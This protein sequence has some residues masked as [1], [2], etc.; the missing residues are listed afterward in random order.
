MTTLHVATQ[1]S[2]ETQ[3]ANARIAIDRAA[4][5]ARARHITT[6]PGQ[7][8]T[9]LSKAAEAVAY[10]AAGAPEDLT[11]W[12]WIQA[13]ASAFNLSGFEAA[14]TIIANRDAWVA[15]GSYIENV[16]LHSKNDIAAAT[17]PMDCAR[18]LQNAIN[19]LN[20]L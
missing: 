1:E 8:E 5:Q 2:I 3:R 4:G 12:P 11:G 17:T 19:T 14:S 15:L 18:I 7:A 13:D 6:T 9:Y 16:R 10:L 20:A